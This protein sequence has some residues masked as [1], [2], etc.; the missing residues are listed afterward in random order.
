MDI[1][2][3]LAQQLAAHLLEED[4]KPTKYGRLV[5]VRTPQ[6][7]ITTDWNGYY[8]M[9]EVGGPLAHSIG[10][11]DQQGGWSHGWLHPGHEILDPVPS[12]EEWSA[13][14]K[15]REQQQQQPSA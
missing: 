5:R 8:D 2:H 3:Q 14:L 6:G 1:R 4:P 9:R 13:E 12:F 10:Y 7:V 11:P 15:A